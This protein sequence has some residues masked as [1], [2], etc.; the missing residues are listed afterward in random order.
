MIDWESLEKATATATV[1]AVNKTRLD[2]KSCL[3]SNKKRLQFGTYKQECEA[4]LAQTTALHSISLATL[5]VKIDE[6]HNLLAAKNAEIGT[7]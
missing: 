7:V 4:H 5:Q 3:L 6:L 1:D 2:A